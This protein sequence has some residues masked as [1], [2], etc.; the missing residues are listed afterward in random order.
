MTGL[1]VLAS[2]LG[3]ALL[4]KKKRINGIGVPNFSPYKISWIILV[5]ESGI[6]TKHDQERLKQWLFVRFLGST[7]LATHFPTKERAKEVLYEISDIQG[8]DKKYRAY[9]ISD[10]QMRF[11]D[12]DNVD[13]ES[14]MTKK[15]IEDSFMI[16]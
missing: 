7:S 15:Q 9:I 1:L 4:S 6:A 3:L 16:G 12:P 2:V 14:V 8:L 10:K 13:Y 11:F 5:P